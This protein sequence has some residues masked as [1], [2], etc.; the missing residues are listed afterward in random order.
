MVPFLAHP[1]YYN[2]TEHKYNNYNHSNCNVL[3]SLFLRNPVFVISIDG[4]GYVQLNV[5]SIVINVT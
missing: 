1:V 5:V 2:I 4:F 3:W